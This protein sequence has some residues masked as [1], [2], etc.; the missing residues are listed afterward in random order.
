MNTTKVLMIN[1]VVLL[2]LIAGGFTGYYYYNQSTLYLKTKN[3]QVAGQQMTIAAPA[4][5]HLKDWKGKSGTALKAGE[6]VG[7]VET[8]GAQGT[9]QVNVTIPQ[10]GTIVQNMAV[11]NQMVAPGTPLAYAYDLKNLWVTA[12]ISETDL[13]DVK[14]GQTVDVYV[15]AYPN[16]TFNGTVEQIGMTTAGTFSLLPQSNSNANYT[17]VTQVIPVKITLNNSQAAGLAPGMSAEVRIHK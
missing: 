10:D 9:A 17:K 8:A 5:G 7:D 3:A 6:T 16:I 12:N 15:D 13:E 2:L 4:A 14:V 1:I 11:D